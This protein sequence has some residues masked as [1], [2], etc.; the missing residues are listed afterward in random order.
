MLGRVA[1]LTIQPYGIELQS[2][3]Y[4]CYELTT[5]RTRMGSRADKQVKIK[6]N[7]A[8]LS[9]IHV[10]DPDEQRYLT[11]PAL[12]QDYT[13]GLSL[14][15]HRVIR[16]FV[17]SEQHTVDLVALGQAQRKIQAIV[18]QSMRRKK[19]STRTKIAR[20]QSQ[21]IDP[22]AAEPASINPVTRPVFDLELDLSQLEREGWGLSYDRSSALISGQT[23]D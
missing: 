12:A 8:D 23:H 6:Y 17:L 21:A 15:K 4:N 2:M 7:P 18:E 9:C 16:N 20:W 1:C 19:L 11:V 22:K 5:L 10:Y 14:W 3:R 13:R